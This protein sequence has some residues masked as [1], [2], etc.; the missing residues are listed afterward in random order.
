M[1]DVIGRILDEGG[2]VFNVAHPRFGATGD[3]TDETVK[4][5]AAI[6]AT[7]RTPGVRTEGSG[8]V[9]F[10]RGKTYR[11]DELL[12]PVGITLDLNG[13]T[14]LRIDPKPLE[15]PQQ[16]TKWRET[17]IVHWSSDLD[18]PVL[19][20]RNGVLDGNRAAQGDFTGHKLEHAHLMFVAAD[21]HKLGRLRLHVDNM[22]FRNGP[23]DGISMTDNVDAQ[24]SNSRF[25]ACWRGAITLTGSNSR[26]QVVNVRIQNT[27]IDQ[28]G[29]D[30][31][32]DDNPTHPELVGRNVFELTNVDIDG[33]F[34]IYPGP[35]GVGLC[36][37]VNVREPIFYINGALSRLHFQNCNFA[38]GAVNDSHNRV[39]SPGDCTFEGCTFTLTEVREAG[40]DTNRQFAAI[41]LFWNVGAEGITNQRLR[42]VNCVWRADASIEPGD[43]LYGVSVLAQTAASGNRL[44]V[45]NA[46]IPGTFDY[47][48]SFEQ[49]GILRARGGHIAAATAFRWST[50]A[51]GGYLMDV[52]VDGVDVRGT[53]RYAEMHGADPGTV[54]RQ[55]NLLIT[56]EAEAAIFQGGTDM[57]VSTWLGGREIL[58]D[59][60]P[61]GRIGGIRGDV[62]RLRTPPAAGGAYEWVCTVGNDT[63]GY[64]TWKQLSTVTP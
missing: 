1:A 48:I 64:A 40:T 17:F 26:V 36:T 24:I 11:V 16:V 31:E 46:E 59:S 25:Q 9:L 55:R 47:G 37:N 21:L 18:S 49:G 28:G 5:Q 61:V 30:L 2:A 13:A 53:S 54:I 60:S 35:N 29:I 10:E 22:V 44:I 52:T 7:L 45:E 23:A 56:S 34:D 3:G 27:A 38:I 63:G 4:I 19:T 32:A 39:V 62:A 57:N 43:V 12:L 41:R 20:V 33:G 42:L 8:T 50:V 58:V 51:S 14:L 15:D 6:D